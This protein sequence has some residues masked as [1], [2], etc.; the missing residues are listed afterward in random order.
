MHVY[1]ASG[2]RYGSSARLFVIPRSCECLD[3]A[4]R[5]LRGLLDKPKEKNAMHQSGIV[6]KDVQVRDALRQ[7]NW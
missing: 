2:I 4:M 5:E 7:A 6:S 1:H 3:P